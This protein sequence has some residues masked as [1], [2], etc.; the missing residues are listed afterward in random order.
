MAG[1]F[2]FVFCYFFIFILMQG[3][4]FYDLLIKYGINSMG[5]NYYYEAIINYAEFSPTFLGIGRNAVTKI[6]TTDLAYMHV[7]GV[8]SDIIKMYVE[9]GFILF[10]WWLWYY[11]VYLTK[12]YRKKY[13]NQSAIL[14]FGLVIYTFTMYLTDNVEIYFICQIIT[15]VLPMTYA[16]YMAKDNPIQQFENKEKSN[17]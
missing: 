1:W 16:M 17:G 9:N 2:A 8:H 3:S 11:L 6:L 15:I 10:G 7:G 14:Y 5:R 4:E 12:V 13:G